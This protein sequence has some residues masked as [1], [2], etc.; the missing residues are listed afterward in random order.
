MRTAVKLDTMPSEEISDYAQKAMLN[1]PF[2]NFKIE[3]YKYAQLHKSI[4]S[5]SSLEAF[6]P[7]FLSINS[8][9]NLKLTDGA[10]ADLLG[11]LNKWNYNNSDSYFRVNSILERS[12]KKIDLFNYGNHTRD[13]TYIDD[14][15]KG[16]RLLIDIIPRASNFIV[17]NSDVLDSKSH[18]APF[19]VVNIGNSKKIKHT[20]FI[21][22]KHLDFTKFKYVR[23]K[24]D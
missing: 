21:G 13:F 12:S 23:N 2:E 24:K 19:R 22:T 11:D 16:M 1:N 17:D 10:N 7:D 15:V 14:L 20:F 8:F 18:V 4:T 6:N 3:N 9:K 5:N